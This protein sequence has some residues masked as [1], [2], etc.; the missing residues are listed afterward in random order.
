MIPKKTITKVGLRR[1]K[2]CSAPDHA[3]KERKE[4]TP[5][6]NILPSWQQRGGTCESA[7]WVRQAGTI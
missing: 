6:R 3:K 7:L 5:L 4:C 1:G 2:R